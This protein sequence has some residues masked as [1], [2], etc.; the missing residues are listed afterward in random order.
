MCSCWLPGLGSGWF[1]LSCTGMGGVSPVSLRRFHF[2]LAAAYVAAALS[3]RLHGKVCAS[4][5]PAGRASCRVIFRR[6]EACCCVF[7]DVQA[8][9]WVRVLGLAVLS[10]A[11]DAPFKSIEHGCVHVCVHAYPFSFVSPLARL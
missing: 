9:G 3:R 11:L 6:R 10:P 1:M 5:F 2:G 8:F 4:F 7:V